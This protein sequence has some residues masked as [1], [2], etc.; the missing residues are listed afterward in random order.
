MEAMED[1]AKKVSEHG[2]KA[3]KKM[4]HGGKPAEHAG[5]PVAK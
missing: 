2:G 1:E 5:K 4:E 3:M